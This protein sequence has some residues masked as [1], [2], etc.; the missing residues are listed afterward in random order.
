MRRP[1]PNILLVDD[2][3][4]DRFLIAAAFVSMGLSAVH[5]V[6]SAEAAIAYLDGSHLYADRTVHPYPDFVITD[7]KMPESDG[8]T[9]LEYLRQTPDSTITR[10]VVLTGSQDNV[11]VMKAYS[12]GAWAYH[13]K[14]SSPDAL[15]SLIKALH[16]YWLMCEVPER[17]RTGSRLK[18]SGRSPSASVSA[19]GS[20]VPVTAAAG[21]GNRWSPPL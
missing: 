4:N 8:F 17:D 18:A 1:N 12:L 19:L 5:S 16:G 10:T 9:V 14:P 11:D 13:V 20:L 6:V 21:S 2:D 3:E 7:L 15:R